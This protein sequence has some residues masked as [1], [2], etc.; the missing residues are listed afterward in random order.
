MLR[1]VPLSE[2]KL[3]CFHEIKVMNSF[4]SFSSLEH[5]RY[6]YWC[7]NGSNGHYGVRT[8]HGACLY[9]KDVLERDTEKMVQVFWTTTVRRIFSH[10]PPSISWKVLTKLIWPDVLHCNR[11]VQVHAY[12]VVKSIAWNEILCYNQRNS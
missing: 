12:I 2:E 4:L 6:N 9:A 11:N 8:L 3:K 10:I 5:L 1:K 7:W